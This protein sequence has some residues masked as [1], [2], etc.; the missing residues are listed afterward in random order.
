MKIAAQLCFIAIL[1][2]GATS[3]NQEDSTSSL[4]VQQTD[5]GEEVSLYRNDQVR[6]LKQGP[7]GEKIF[8]VVEEMPMFG[9]C[10]TKKCSDEKLIKYLQDN[11]KYPKVALDAKVE[12]KVFV[13]FVIRNDGAV[14]DIEVVRDIGAGCGQAAAD[15]VLEMN[16]LDEGWTPGF[17]NGESVNVMYTIPVT[18]KLEV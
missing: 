3:C 5:A 4:Q 11:L 2:I 15:L 17:Q 12:G 8:A 6:I 16:D 14:S 1:I 9:G 18:Y 7:E 10:K 13:Q